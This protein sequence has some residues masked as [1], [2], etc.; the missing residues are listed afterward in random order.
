MSNVTFVLRND[1]SGLV[2]VSYDLADPDSPA[3]NVLV[4]ASDDGGTTWNL[5]V[6]S[7][8]GHVGSG[9]AAG[10][11]RAVVWDFGADHPGAVLPAV[12]I[13]VTA[14]DGP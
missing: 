11:A 4:E 13:R 5:S 2:D 7:V 14:S 3:L 1:G 12:V 9:V 10:A 8:T 6:N